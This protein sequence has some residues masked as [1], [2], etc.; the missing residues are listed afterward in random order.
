MYDELAQLYRKD[1]TSI[2]S[3]EE[4]LASYGDVTRDG[5]LALSDV[6][7]IQ[8]YLA[9]AAE[10]SSADRKF[11]DYDANGFINMTDVLKIQNKLAKI[12]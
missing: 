3:A 5:E 12:A 10:L 1:Y 2:Y 9:L 8:K 11:A 7:E 6:L 4:S